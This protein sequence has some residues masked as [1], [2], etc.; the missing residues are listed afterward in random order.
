MI[1]TKDKL[2]PMSGYS[3]A[4]ILISYWALPIGTF[5]TGEYTAGLLVVSLL[6]ILMYLPL[7]RSY[8]FHNKVIRSVVCSLMVLMSGGAFVLTEKFGGVCV[9]HECRSWTGFDF[10]F[11]IPIMVMVV[12]MFNAYRNAA[13]K[14]V[15]LR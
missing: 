3:L 14:Y 15:D 12:S 5:R 9:N 8:I 2:P 7:Y 11:L 6:Y 1:E 13:E 10:V 4:T